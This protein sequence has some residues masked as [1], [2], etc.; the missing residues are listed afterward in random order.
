MTLDKIVH[1]PIIFAVKEGKIVN[2]IMKDVRKTT[3]EDGLC[4]IDC[5]KD[6]RKKNKLK[7]FYYP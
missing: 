2:E 5:K 6:N 7:I 3:V 1:I 4:L